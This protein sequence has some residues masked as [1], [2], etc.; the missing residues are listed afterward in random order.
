MWKIEKLI[1]Q[2]FTHIYS[3]LGK[4]EVIL[5]L[6]DNDKIINVFIGKMGSGK[7]AILGHLQP[8]SNYG[9]LDIRNQDDPIIPEENG[10]KEIVYT[11]NESDRYVIQHLYNWNKVTKSHNAKSYIQLNGNELNPNGNMNSFKEIIRVHFGI[12]QNFLRLL[13]LGPNVANLIEMR[14][15]ERKAFIASLLKDTD[16]YTTLFKHL[17]EDLRAINATLSVLSK[18][19]VSLSSTEE[20]NLK[21]KYKAAL[22][23]RQ[24]LADELELVKNEFFRQQGLLSHIL[25][26][27]SFDNL[28]S[29]MQNKT[30]SLNEMRDE[31]K[32]IQDDLENIPT[33]K[34]SS[35]VM[36][37]IGMVEMSLNQVIVQMSQLE[38]D[39]KKTEIESARL[40]D[41]L[42]IRSNDRQMQN[43]KESLSILEERYETS[44]RKIKG[45]SCSYSYRFL[46]GF[47]DSLSILSMQ[48]REMSGYSRETINMVY[49]ADSTISQVVN[50]KI[51]IL[52]GKVVNLRKQVS[53][54]EFSA[55]YHTPLP[56][57]R[58]PMC[59]TESCPFIQTHPDYI[60][61]ITKNMSSKHYNPAQTILNQIDELEREISLYREL[62][63]LYQ[64][65]Q[66]IKNGWNESS[67]ILSNLGVLLHSQLYKI[68]TNGPMY[69][70]W[71]DHEELTNILEKCKIQE[72]LMNLEKQVLAAKNELQS[73]TTENGG[74]LN[75]EI[76]KADALSQR[77]HSEL[78]RLSEEKARLSAQSDQLY[79]TYERIEASALIK[80]RA[81]E[82]ELS[83][84]SLEKEVERLLS[85]IEEAKSILKSTNQFQIKIGTLST[86]IEKITQEIETIKM[87]LNDI[88]FTKKEY[89][90]A[91]NS[92][93][94]LKDIIDAVST[95]EG[96]PL[97]MVKVFLDDCRE[98]LNELIADVFPDNLEILEFNIN[99]SEFKI[100]YSVNGWEIDDIDT[101]SQGQRAIISIALSFALVRQSMFDYNIMLLDEVDGP[102]YKKDRE[103]F[104]AIL[105]KQLQAI[106]ASQVFLITHNNTFENSPVNIIMTTEEMVETSPSSTVMRLY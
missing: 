56:L 27:S 46:G 51:D 62:P 103:K 13:R 9:T 105:F 82:L 69:L 97:I 42:Q 52:T 45:F 33:N 104:I 96:I 25:N 16:V 72:E 15:T 3:G 88:K 34:T 2:N 14:S 1:L 8:F 98:I 67:N 11:H 58:P 80:K 100:P 91:A 35:E 12:E 106:G 48:I 41:I 59:P 102:L 53:N 61:R 22:E 65:M 50:R 54:I 83:I 57:V 84:A 21:A 94:E 76:E 49:Y 101:A 86:Q 74:N 29:E 89:G 5:D 39:I 70:N 63:V 19:L 36:K 10:Y 31:F 26:G 4:K 44:K 66:I 99:E 73:L 30:K 79:R 60:K 77:Y 90:D 32:S 64:K 6:S 95:K 40:K 85:S 43:L 24:E 7:S 17:S 68:L 93:E 92:R 55:Q 18:K 20:D 87:R 75:E 71:Y 28:Q 78:Q 37:D 38:E 23:E 81:S 47:I